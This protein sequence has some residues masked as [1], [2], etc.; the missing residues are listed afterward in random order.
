MF[1]EQILGFICHWRFRHR[2]TVGSSSPK[3]SGTKRM[4]NLTNG[5]LWTLDFFS[6][7]SLQFISLS[8]NH[9]IHLSQMLIHNPHWHSG[10]NEWTR[11][12][13]QK[14]LVSMMSTFGLFPESVMVSQTNLTLVTLYLL[15]RGRHGTS[16]DKM[17]KKQRRM[18]VVKRHHR[19]ERR[20]VW[21]RKRSLRMD[22]IME[23]PD[24]TVRNQTVNLPVK[25]R[26]SKR[27]T[28]SIL[29][30]SNASS[31]DIFHFLPLPHFLKEVWQEIASRSDPTKL[32]SFPWL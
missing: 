6:C 25:R 28:A 5:S 1:S 22:P 11:Q 10:N 20:S 18:R 2:F 9:S 30:T 14:K 26:V 4:G 17:D 23:P 27:G 29:L 32:V 16:R 7:R 13:L 31:V 12:N 19:S 15:W 24:R 21:Q 8:R 3:T